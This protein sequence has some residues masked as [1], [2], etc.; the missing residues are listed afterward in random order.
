[1][2][3]EETGMTSN[4]SYRL[5][6]N[7]RPEKYRLTLRP[8]LGDFTFQGE[9]SV[10]LRVVEPDSS[11]TLNAAE[12]QISSARVTLQDGTVL[13]A[14]EI[15]LDESREKATFFFDR[16]LPTGPAALAVDFNG[17]L[18]DQLQGF[19]RSRYIAPDGEECYLAATQFEATDARR[20]FPCWD[21]PALKSTFEVTLVVPSD[22]TAISNTHVVSETSR[23]DGTK[24]VRFAETPKMSTYLLAFIVGD[25]ASIET[26]APDGTLVRVWAPRGKEG[27]GHFA[28]DHAVRLL[29]YFNDYFGIPYPLKKLDHIAIPDFAAGAMENW[30]AITYREAALLYDPENSAAHT[31]QRI[32]EIIAHE[33]AHMWFGDLATM[34]WWD[35]LW[36]NESFASWIGNKATGHLHPEWSM[37]TQFISHD[38][39]AGLNLDGLKNSHPIEA[40]VNNPADIRELFDQISYSKGAAVLWMLEQFLGEETFRRGLRHYLSAHQYGNART[41]DLWKA[42]SNASGQ[43]VNSLMNTWVK[44]TGFP[45][46]QVSVQREESEVRLTLS[47]RR[48]LYEHLLSSEEDDTLWEVPVSFLRAGASDVDSFLMQDRRVARSLGA[49][50]LPAFDD[51]VKVNAGQTGFYRVNYPPGEWMRLRPAIEALQLPPADRLG[52]LSDAFSLMRAGYAPASLFLSL[53][54]AYK[55]EDDA[56][57]WGELS[58]N[59][60]ALAGLIV[61]EPYLPQLYNYTREIYRSVVQRVGWDAGADEGHLDALLRSTVL[62]GIGS[63]GELPVI[64]EAQVR[65]EDYLKDPTS[66]NPDIRGVVCGLAGSGRRASHL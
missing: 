49:E 33:T 50:R 2:W 57:V 27:Y 18:N 13:P 9:E 43:P 31:R 54:E 64:Q 56:T 52:L 42:L 3:R 12:L 63:W 34:E 24:V 38:T 17:T 11:I 25:M 65:F 7:V 55:N 30:G 6:T 66:L 20:A 37:W 14:R 4:D 21:E 35:D 59:L 53:A 19:Y 48:F 15:H 45:V 5:P 61:D 44:Q 46:L 58:A 8:D 36:L 60:R 51:W 39:N 28:L 16:T 41:E 47:Q 1:M 29:T 40:T 62:G 26:T 23:E 32:V 10:D 22:L